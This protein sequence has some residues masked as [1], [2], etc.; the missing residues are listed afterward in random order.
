MYPYC[1]ERRPTPFA[2]PFFC[3]VCDRYAV[4]GVS[5]SLN[6]VAGMFIPDVGTRVVCTVDCEAIARIELALL[7]PLEE[8]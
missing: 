6:A 5:V 3:D 4:G 7:V 2:D 8:T 1:W